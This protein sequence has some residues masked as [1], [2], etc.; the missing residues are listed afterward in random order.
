MLTTI[1]A[2]IDRHGQV[3]LL[4]EVTLNRPRR[5]LVTILDEAEEAEFRGEE[6][7]RGT[8]ATALAFL[9]DNRLPATALPTAEEMEVQIKEAR[10]SWD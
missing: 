4:E 10:E 7:R 6:P 2:E 9:R 1:H 3:H 5:A 8:A